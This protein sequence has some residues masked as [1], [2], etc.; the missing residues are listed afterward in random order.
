MAVAAAPPDAT[1][2]GGPAPDPSYTPAPTGAAAAA[3]QAVAAWTARLD[4]Q[5]SLST[6]SAAGALAAAALAAVLTFRAVGGALLATAAPPAPATAAAAAWT[7]LGWPAPAWVAALLA[8]LA[9]GLACR[10]AAL[11]ACRASTAA[12][13]ADLAD[14]DSRFASVAGLAVHY[15]AARPPPPGSDAAGSAPPPPAAPPVALALYHGFGAGAFSWAFVH[16]PLA[17]ACS[18]LVTKHDMPGFGLTD[19]PGAGWAGWAGRGRRGRG[20]GGAHAD[21][22]GGLEPYSLSFNG[23]VGASVLDLELLLCA[24]PATS[25]GTPPLPTAPPLPPP[26]SVADAV[27]ARAARRGAGGP[28]RVL[29]GHSLGAVCAAAE[30]VRDP[31][32][33]DALVLI[34]PAIV[35]ASSSSASKGAGA[36]AAQ[37]EAA[38]GAATSLAVWVAAA[39]AAV[40]ASARLAAGL[41]ARL[42]ILVAAPLLVAL[43][44]A[45]VRSR[46]FWER[47]LGA[48][49]GDD[50]APPGWLT[51]AYRAPQLLVGWERGLLRF[52][53]ARIPLGPGPLAVL[54]AAAAAAVAG[55]RGGS[56]GAAPAPASAA[57]RL[58]AVV[59]AT[60]LPV[61]IIHGSRDM[62]VPPSN[63]LRLAD[64]LRGGRGGGA[65]GG[66]RNVGGLVS[67]ALL[68]RRGHT[69]HEEA[70]AE[71][72]GV[73]SSFVGGLREMGRGGG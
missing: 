52:C 29:V 57:A 34:A 23:R 28:L 48:A 46:A 47:G 7:I 51:D 44:R 1:A 60:G 63:S 17:A 11:E 61:L 37:P 64:Q 72:V 71:F 26:C 70:P 21:V 19:R 56:L 18:A 32:R 4:E 66:D 38:P 45:A 8:G 69:P 15:K 49:W 58:A 62:L 2:A 25:A 13:A 12:V 33:V 43:L 39:L 5:P 40:A 35:A 59:G 55:G 22:A 27:A 41:A 24:A 20:T 36:R 30:A 9:A 68:P 3:A 50:G 14:P 54:R 31:G 6:S 67:V 53:A 65:G 42:A 16:R 73:V 10:S